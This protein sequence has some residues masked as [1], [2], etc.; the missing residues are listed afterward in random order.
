MRSRQQLEKKANGLK[1]VKEEV[2]EGKAA[3][4]TSKDGVREKEADNVADATEER[5]GSVSKSS[6]VH[7]APAA[8]IQSKPFFSQDDEL[9]CE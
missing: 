7:L 5:P 2:D 8:V 4:T 3:T 1:V 6:K 9:Y